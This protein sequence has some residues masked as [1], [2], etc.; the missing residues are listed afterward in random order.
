[1]KYALAL[2]LS[3][4]AIPAL[5]GD[6]K[7]GSPADKFDTKQPIEISSDALEVLQHENKAIFKGNVIA[8]QGQVRLKSDV[9]TVHYTPKTDAGNTPAPKPQATPAAP[10]AM[11]AISLIEVNGHVFIATPEESARGDKG[12]YHVN[13][14]LIH[15]FGPDVTLTRDKNILKGTALEY[16]L[17]T[18]RSV[19]T[20]GNNQVNGKPDGRVRSVFVPQ[21]DPAKP[22]VKAPK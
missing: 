22:G 7:P 2:I 18:G 1:M 15:L 19:L 13:D 11:G 21:Q 10:G 6:A 14:H 8:V 4:L 20:G 5:A 9:M 3:L 16:N 12:D 17:M